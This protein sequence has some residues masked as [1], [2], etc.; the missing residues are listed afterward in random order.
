MWWLWEVMITSTGM[1]LW[2]LKKSSPPSAAQH[3]TYLSHVLSVIFLSFI[4][5]ASNLFEHFLAF[6]SYFITAASHLFE[7]FCA[8]FHLQMIMCCLRHCQT[9]THLIV[10]V[11]HDSF[12]PLNQADNKYEHLVE[13]CCRRDVFKDDWRR[14]FIAKLYRNLRAGVCKILSIS[15]IKLVNS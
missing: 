12:A 9:F 6:F 5:A 13:F 1:G 11:K 7:H 4:T 14:T 3:P 2:R 8:I 15:K 10:L